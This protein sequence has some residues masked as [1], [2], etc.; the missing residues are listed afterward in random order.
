MLDSVNKTNVPSK[1]TQQEAPMEPP[2]FDGPPVTHLLRYLYFY[3]ND[4]LDVLKM[5][6]MTNKIGTE[7]GVH[8]DY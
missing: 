8:K 7:I 1:M 3:I 2:H 4:S 5:N 6:N